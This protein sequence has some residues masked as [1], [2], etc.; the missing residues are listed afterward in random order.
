MWLQIARQYY[1]LIY[2]Q[3]ITGNGIVK[4]VYRLQCWTAMAPY[5]TRRRLSDHADICRTSEDACLQ[6]P[7]PRKNRPRRN[8]RFALFQTE[9]IGLRYLTE[10]QQIFPDAT[11]E[12]YVPK[13]A[14]YRQQT[15]C[16]LLSTSA[17]GEPT[18]DVCC[19]RNLTENALSITGKKFCP[20]VRDSLTCPQ[21]NFIIRTSPTKAHCQ[22]FCLIMVTGTNLS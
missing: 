14:A 21:G 5:S 19:F 17:F 12:E 7:P 22:T 11:L 9:D 15:E 10:S 6:F 2:F 16:L 1:R 18:G 20:K 8:L 3:L 4:T 13:L